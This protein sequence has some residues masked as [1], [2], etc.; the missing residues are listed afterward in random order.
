MRVIDFRSFHCMD[1]DDSDVIYGTSL[2]TVLLEPDVPAAVVPIR[3]LI[4]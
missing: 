4:H 2:R 1:N 3:L